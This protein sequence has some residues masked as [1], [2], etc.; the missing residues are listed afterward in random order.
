MTVLSRQRYQMNDIDT[1]S[2]LLV[3]ICGLVNLVESVHAAVSNVGTQRKDE[4]GYSRDSYRVSDFFCSEVRLRFTGHCLE[5]LLLSRLTSR[6]RLIHAPL[7]KYKPTLLSRSTAM[8]R[9]TCNTTVMTRLT[10][11]AV[12]IT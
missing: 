1:P 12:R 11:S 8:Y 2:G 4:V 10:S 6:L 7:N 5:E 3:G 9:I